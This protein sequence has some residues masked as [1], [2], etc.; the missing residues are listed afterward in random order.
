M[1]HPTTVVS[2]LSDLQLLKFGRVL[3]DRDAFPILWVLLE[4]ES[5]LSM[6]QLSRNL[7]INPAELKAIISVLDRE[8]LIELKGKTYTPRA[9][10]R[11]CRH[12][13]EAAVESA[14]EVESISPTIELEAQSEER[15][16]VSP[17]NLLEDQ[18]A[19]GLASEIAAETEIATER[20]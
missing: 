8:G 7:G 15:S 2:E 12:L 18:R 14:I 10:A 3:A 4:S 19:K 16:A 6:A 11:D 13:L 20:R 5:P 9:W 17:A 1:K